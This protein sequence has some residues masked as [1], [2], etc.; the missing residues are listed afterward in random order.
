MECLHK[1][2][3]TRRK[4]SHIVKYN[5]EKVIQIREKIRIVFGKESTM[6]D[7]ALSERYNLTGDGDLI[8]IL[9]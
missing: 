3:E 8:M 2:I 4:E 9:R 5:A 7:L 1:S 6:D